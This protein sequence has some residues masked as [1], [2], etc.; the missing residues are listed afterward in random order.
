MVAR[1]RLSYVLGL[2]LLKPFRHSEYR[3]L[4]AALAVSV[5]GAGMWTVVMPMQVLELKD[6]DAQGLALVVTSYGCSALLSAL[7]G[8]VAADRLSQRRII[9]GVQLLNFLTLAAI[10]PLAVIDRLQLWELAVAA[11]LLGVGSGLF[12]PAFTA[13]LPRILPEEDL[14]AANGVDGV[15]RSTLQ[16]A[17]GPTLAG[18]LLGA[19]YPDTGLVII[20]VLFAISLTLLL[21]LRPATAPPAAMSRARVGA[22]LRDG[23]SFVVTTRW[24]LWTLVV[25]AVTAFSVTGPAEV[26]LPYLTQEKF[27]DGPL[28]FGSLL[29]AVGIGAA[30]GAITVSSRG[31][32]R[33]YLT[34]LN[35]GT[36]AGMLPLILLGN[37][38]VFPIMAAAA[39]A[40]GLVQGMALV[41]RATLLQRRV[42]RAKLGRVASVDVFVT[43]A[44]MPVSTAVTGALSEV[45][46]PETIFAV[47]GCIPI[48]AAFIAVVAARMNRDELKHPLR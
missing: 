25:T 43:L 35:L 20:A 40:I 13:Y 17:I 1:D 22:D 32:P 33:H 12:A 24:L 5:I 46:S 27:D 42:P 10:A 34:V 21:T 16:Q 36:A 19:T 15:M 37:T 8:G 30:V 4:I 9:L 7:V 11:T 38:S 14:V 29:A 3:R 23:L 47:A 45:V 48:V 6:D 39:V 26:L 31:L 2:R 28:A 44:L 41:I 18:V